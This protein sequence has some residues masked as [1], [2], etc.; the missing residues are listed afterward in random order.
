LPEET[1]GRASISSSREQI[2]QFWINRLCRQKL[3]TRCRIVAHR[4]QSVD[5][6]S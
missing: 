1:I 6:R 4:A 5:R 3:G 2:V